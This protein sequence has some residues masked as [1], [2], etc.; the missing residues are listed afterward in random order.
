MKFMLLQDYAPTEG[1][2]EFIGAWSPVM[3]RRTSSSSAR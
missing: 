2:A 1:A 3:R